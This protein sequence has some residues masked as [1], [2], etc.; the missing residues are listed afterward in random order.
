ME[1]LTERDHLGTAICKRSVSD[2]CNGKCDECDYDYDCF[3]KLTDYEDLEEQ[4]LL[5]IAPLKDG[6]PIYAI[7]EDC[8]DFGEKERYI[9]RSSYL[10]GVTEYEFGELNKDFFISEQAAENNLR[11]RSSKVIADL[12]EFYQKWMKTN[13]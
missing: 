12:E 10:H 8:V 7:V 5:H 3:K 6:T 13:V 1:R 4:G 2:Y 9:V 11:L